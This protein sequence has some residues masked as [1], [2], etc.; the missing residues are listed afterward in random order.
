MVLWS[1]VLTT[2]TLGQLTSVES[3]SRAEPS[4]VA[5]PVAVLVTVPQVVGVVGEETW[6]VLLAPGATSPKEQVS[7]RS[8][9]RRVGAQWTSSTDQLRA[10][11]VGS[12]S[13]RITVLATP[14]P[15]G[16]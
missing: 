4:L 8:E 12:V 11:C 5:P 13:V 15:V 16:V 7:T 3:P 6:T 9:E 1:E 2:D 14:G 10:A